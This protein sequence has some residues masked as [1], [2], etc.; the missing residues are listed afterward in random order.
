MGET[1][2]NCSDSH[3]DSCMREKIILRSSTN[4]D[5]CPGRLWPVHLAIQ[6]L[7]EELY[8][9]SPSCSE[10][11]QILLSTDNNPVIWELHTLTSGGCSNAYQKKSTKESGCYWSMLLANFSL[12]GYQ[13]QGLWLKIEKNPEWLFQYNKPTMDI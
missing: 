7:N 5:F 9:K 8:R 11:I 12:P 6:R 13:L 2:T 1:S 10:A 3:W 4:S